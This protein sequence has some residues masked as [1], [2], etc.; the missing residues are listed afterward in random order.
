[1]K[2]WLVLYVGTSIGGTWG[3]LPYDM[4]KCE[5]N[6][7]IMMASVAEVRTNPAKIAKLKEEGRFQD[8]EK[9]FFKCE[10]NSVRPK[11][12]FVR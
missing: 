10:R 3:P 4:D 2:L 12:T 5:D 8:F 7:K 1:L 9:M 11:I 6:A